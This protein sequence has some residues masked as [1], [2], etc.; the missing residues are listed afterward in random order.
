MKRAIVIV[1]D[2]LGIGALPDA[3]EFG[4]GPDCCTLGN[5]ARSNGGLHLPVLG[6]LGLGCIIPVD[7]VPPADHPLASFG[8]MQ[9]QSRG[10]DTTTGHWE[11]AG[12]VTK[13]PFATFPDGFPQEFIA[14]FVRVNQL[15][16][17]LCNKPASGTAVLEAFG[18]EHLGGVLRT[19]H[20]S[21]R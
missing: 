8:R 1:I 16:G 15:P 21:H 14:E 7:G 10:K 19:L 18:R 20:L 9:E 4:D 13:T 11:L 2:A 6:S 3:A 5:V 12:L 17:V